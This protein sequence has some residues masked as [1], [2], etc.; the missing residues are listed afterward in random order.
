MKIKKNEILF[1]NLIKS[2]YAIKAT[3]SYLLLLLFEKM[4]LKRSE[5]L[6][7]TTKKSEKK[8]F[9]DFVK[10]LKEVTTP[11]MKDETI[12]KT[13]LDNTKI[14]INLMKLVNNNFNLIVQ[15]NFARLLNSVYYNSFRWIKEVKIYCVEKLLI[16]QKE[17]DRFRKKY[18]TFKYAKWKFI[19]ECYGLDDHLMKAIGDYI[20]L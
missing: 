8:H 18:E 13:S 9:D 11:I 20:R 17:C 2:I 14:A 10:K 5:R 1:I 6:T 19:R 12:P 4:N 7:E 16:T 15:F 3:L